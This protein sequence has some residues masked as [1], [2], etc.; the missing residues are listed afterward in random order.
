MDALLLMRAEFSLLVCF[1]LES[2][3]MDIELRVEG[4]RLTPPCVSCMKL[5]MILESYWFA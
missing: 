5:M 3:L 2:A 4:F 1:E